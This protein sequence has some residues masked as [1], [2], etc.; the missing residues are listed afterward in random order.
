ME[1]K[2]IDIGI[3]IGKDLVNTYLTADSENYGPG[4]PIL[5]TS[6]YKPGEEIIFYLYIVL[7]ID[8]WSGVAHWYTKY[9]I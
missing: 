7:F 4:V 6:L 2:R 8:H 3:R 9:N 1:L 5:L